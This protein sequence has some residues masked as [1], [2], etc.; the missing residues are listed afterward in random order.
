MLLT[1]LF[2]TLSRQQVKRI[3]TL[4]NELNSLSESQLSVASLQKFIGENQAKITELEKVF[5]TQDTIVEFLSVTEKLVYELDPEGTV[6][7]GALTPTKMNDELFIPLIFTF[8]A[9]SA[10][11]LE[12]LRKLERLPYI[13]QI[14]TVEFKLPLGQFG[15]GEV[16]LGGKVYVQDPFNQP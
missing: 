1:G 11:A 4:E 12:F 5:P 2:I 6:K 7:F 3:K 10:Q 14:T 9:N 16:V 15:T 13:I 8:K